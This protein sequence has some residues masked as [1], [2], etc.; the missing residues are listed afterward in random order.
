MEHRSVASLL[1][2]HLR[3]TDICHIAPRAVASATFTCAP[4]RSLGAD[5][6][7]PRIRDGLDPTGIHAASSIGKSI[8]KRSAAKK[9]NADWWLRLGRGAGDYRYQEIKA[10]GRLHALHYIRIQATSLLSSW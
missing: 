9:S 2:Q 8:V 10:T 4:E 6:L 1:L 5:G 3:P 7:D